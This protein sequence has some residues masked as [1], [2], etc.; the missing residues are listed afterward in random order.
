MI[1]NYVRNVF[2]KL[3]V[4]VYKKLSNAMNIPFCQM[5]NE[6]LFLGDE[7]DGTELDM[8]QWDYRL[9]MMGRRHP[10]WICS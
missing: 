9:S 5:A 6:N 7:F 8:P 1:F 4:A 3:V 2:T 10:A